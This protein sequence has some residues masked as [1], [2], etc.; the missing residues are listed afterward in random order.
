VCVYCSFDLLVMREVIQK[1]SGIEVSEEAT[2]DQLDALNG[3]EL[4]KQEVSE[5]QGYCRGYG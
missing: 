5:G 4:L 3:G 1:M 2:A